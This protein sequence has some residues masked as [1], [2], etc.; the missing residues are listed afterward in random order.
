MNIG[1]ARSELNK[2]PR[3]KLSVLVYEMLAVLIVCIGMVELL[4]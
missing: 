4:G 2:P 1:A 3:V